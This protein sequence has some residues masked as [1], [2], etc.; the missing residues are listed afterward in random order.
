MRKVWVRLALV[1]GLALS[2]ICQ[3]AADDRADTL[4]ALIRAKAGI[5]TGVT[6]SEFAVMVRQIDEQV[7]LARATKSRDLTQA[8]LEA[9]AA[10]SE[11]LKRVLTLWSYLLTARQCFVQGEYS[12]SDPSCQKELIYRLGLVDLKLD[13]TIDAKAA[14][15][16][17]KSIMGPAFEKAHQRVSSVI[18]LLAAR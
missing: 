3:A 16:T 9:T 4:K 14:A 15:V 6:A 10:A 5:E 7:Q 12:I 2:N 11:H 1:G 13:E 18:G 8:Q 17:M